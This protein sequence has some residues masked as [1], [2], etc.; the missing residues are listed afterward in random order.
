MNVSR[1]GNIDVVAYFIMLP[2]YSHEKSKQ[3]QAKNVNRL[4]GLR[5]ETV[6]I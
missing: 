4:R 5:F 2:W 3:N 1:A 6:S